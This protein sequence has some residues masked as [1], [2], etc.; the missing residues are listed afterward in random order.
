MTRAPYLG[1]RGHRLTRF[2]IGAV[3]CPAYMLLGYNNAV[4]GGLVN[5]ASFLETF[6]R[7]DTVNTEG[8]EEA[9]NARIQ[10][11]SPLAAVH[12]HEMLT[13]PRHRRGPVHRR[14]HAR[15]PLLL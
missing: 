4:F 10:G 11:T 13:A 1:L 15:R 6:P 12:R 3:V 7:I 5:L 8:S 2:M 9:E 14:L